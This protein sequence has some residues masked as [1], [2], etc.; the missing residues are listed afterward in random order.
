MSES[1]LGSI[2]LRSGEIV[3]RV[4]V[5]KPQKRTLLQKL[6]FY[7]LENFDELQTNMAVA[8]TPRSEP[9]F[10]KLVKP[11]TFKGTMAEDPTD[12]IDL[13]ENFYSCQCLNSPPDTYQRMC[14]SALG[15]FLE[16][17]ARDWYRNHNIGSLIKWADMKEAF[18]VYFGKLS[19]EEEQTM[20]F[21]KMSEKESIDDFT[22]RI[23]YAF[24]RLG[25]PE[26]EKTKRFM[27]AVTPL[28]KNEIERILMHEKDKDKV[29]FPQVLSIARDAGDRLKV[30]IQGSRDDL[31]N[32]LVKSTKERAV[33]AIADEYG[34]PPPPVHRG[35]KKAHEPDIVAEVLSTLVSKGAVINYAGNLYT[36]NREGARDQRGSN[37][38]R[39]ET[40]A[41]CGREGHSKASCKACFYC[42]KLG[43]IKRK[44]L[45]F[46]SDM[47]RRQRGDRRSKSRSPSPSSSRKGGGN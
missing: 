45:K 2:K 42:G 15:N 44:C 17:H 47:Q 32:E 3:R 39:K 10:V 41:N 29:S 7:E 16:G 4:V 33:E 35:K 12:W 36:T 13:Y 31:C 28:F 6:P 11:T 30:Y 38:N 22:H 18:L 34:L 5:P 40:C 19:A 8:P 24:R 25:T 46:A 14:R 1:S 26:A 43:H 37:S 21:L 27:A 20:N 23:C 9:S